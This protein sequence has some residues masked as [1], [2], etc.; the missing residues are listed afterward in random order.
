MARYLSDR[1]FHVYTID[2]RGFGEWR[3]PKSK[4][5]ADPAIHFT[6]SK[7][8][9]SKLLEALR[10]KYPNVPIYCLG[11]S[12]G[13]N[14]AL[15]QASTKPELLDGAVLVNVSYKVCVHPRPLWVKT[16]FQGLSHPKTPFN[17]VPYLKPLLSENK[18]LVQTCLSDTNTCTA[19]SAED[20][21]KAAVTNRRTVQQLDKIPENM[22]IL[23]LAG[24]KDKIQKTNKLPDMVSRMSSKKTELVILQNKGH[25]LVE[26]QTPQKDVYEILDNWLTE[27]TSSKVSDRSGATVVPKAT[28]VHKETT[29]TVSHLPTM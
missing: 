9:L 28:E 3:N 29:G 6:Q 14:Y 18:S 12:I 4:F 5:G 27:C 25:M 23:I 15:W 16:F 2:L 26:H 10:Q 11:E 20:L 19:M 13:A 1:Q 24:Q 21:I 7:D 22:P 8:D 17:L